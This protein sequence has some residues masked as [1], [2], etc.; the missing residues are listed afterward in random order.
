MPPSRNF[1]R[2]VFVSS[3]SFPDKEYHI[4][5][6]HGRR[7][8]GCGVAQI[9]PAHILSA[10]MTEKFD[11]FGGLTFFYKDGHTLHT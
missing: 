3:S 9:T 7:V 2:E 6:L 10:P 11:P 4:R 5:L 1:D 8:T